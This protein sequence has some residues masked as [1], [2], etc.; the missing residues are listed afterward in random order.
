MCVTAPSCPTAT[1]LYENG[2]V[3]A[4]DFGYE[5][6]PTLLEEHPQAVL[7]LD[8]F[9]PDA[10]DLA[11]VAKEFQLHPLA[12]EDAVLDHERPKLDRYPHHVFLNVYAVD[13]AARDTESTFG[14]SEISAFV[15]RGP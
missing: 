14:K 3:V 2:K 11:V 12:V 10:D 13:I 1:R 9:D 5:Q 6:V 4:Q 15:T 7:W 8:L